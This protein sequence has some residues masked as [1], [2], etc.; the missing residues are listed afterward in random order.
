MAGAAAGGAVAAFIGLNTWKKQI[1]WEQGRGLAIRLLHTFNNVQRQIS[2]VLEFPRPNHNGILGLLSTEEQ[3][4]ELKASFDIYRAR[5]RNELD[6]FEN[7]CSEAFLVWG[8][9]FQEVSE[10]L[11]EIERQIVILLHETQAAHDPD[12][13]DQHKVRMAE[14]ANELWDDVWG[15][16]AERKS[17]TSEMAALR[18]EL[19]KI[20]QAKKL[21]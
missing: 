9:N 3:F 14:S 1:R 6:D 13:H 15:V 20:L 2:R 19:E 21:R 12:S 18:L 10:P 7:M 5:L 16:N 4:A 17:I 8:V 11:R